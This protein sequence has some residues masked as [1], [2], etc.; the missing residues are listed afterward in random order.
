M[1]KLASLAILVLLF[2]L[3]LRSGTLTT[4]QLIDWSVQA[5]DWTMN[6]A[7]QL[8]ERLQEKRGDTSREHPLL[9]NETHPLPSDYQAA[10][11]ICLYDQPRSFSL[12][13]SDMYLSKETFEAA[14]RMFSAAQAEGMTGYILTSAYRTREQQAEIYAQSAAGL[15][16]KPGCSEHETGLSFDVTVRRDTGSFENTPE[17][18]WLTAH[19]HE[20]GF[21]QRYPPE[22]ETVTGISYEPWHYRYVGEVAAKEIHETAC[23]LEEYLKQ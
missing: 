2:A 11:L 15:A 19:C 8:T 13:R 22:K 7:T 4:E 9:V 21:I 1:K 12:M 5:L 14:E 18:Q 16:Q 10:N 17:C 6:A 3:L 23:V 20:Y